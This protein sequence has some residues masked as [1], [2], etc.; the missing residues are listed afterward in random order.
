MI[1]LIISNLSQLA[2]NIID[3]INN[4]FL[5]SSLL[6]IL[7]LKY[8]LSKQNDLSNSLIQKEQDK[9]CECC[10]KSDEESLKYKAWLDSQ[11]LN[12]F[13]TPEF[14]SWQQEQKEQKE[15]K[16]QLELQRLEEYNNNNK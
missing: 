3:F 8:S 11:P 2:Q 14:E 12:L 9:K 4:I 5:L 13:N 1:Q 6:N 16:E 7:Y 15:Q 10:Y